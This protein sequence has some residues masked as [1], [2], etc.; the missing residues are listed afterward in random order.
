VS[1]E[2]I[3]TAN[4]SYTIFTNP[5]TNNGSPQLIFAPNNN[6]IWQITYNTQLGLQFSQTAFNTTELQLQP[7][8]LNAN[9]QLLG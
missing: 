4:N 8:S 5:D 1:F 7:N 2:G 6:R 3:N 9:N